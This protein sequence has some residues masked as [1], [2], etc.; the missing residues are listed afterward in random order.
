VQDPEHK[1]ADWLPAAR[2]GSVDALGQALEA[3]RGY[4]L[5]IAQRE[6]DADLKAKGGASDLVQE[7][8]LEVQRD[9][10]Q[11]KGDSEAELLAW[12]RRMLLNN[13]GNFAR[14]FHATDKRRVS[15]EVPLAGEH[16]SMGPGLTVAAPQPTPSGEVLAQERADAVRQALQ[17][18]P[19]DYR[20]VLVLR[21]E[22][23]RTFT[24]IGHL[25]GRSGNAIR[26]LWLRAVERVQHE[27]GDSL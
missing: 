13:I 9:F 2:Q 6:L 17:R 8:F 26:K 14:Q 25:M 15:R 10:A 21:Y 27:L 11:F 4:L 5:L 20:Q 19:D 22:E 16:S 23:G 12:L 18:L 7:T 1:V 24:E 3:C